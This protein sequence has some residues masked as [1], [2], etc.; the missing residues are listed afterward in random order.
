M[1]VLNN[2]SKQYKG[3]DVTKD[4][5]VSLWVKNLIRLTSNKATPLLAVD[6][7]SFSVDRGEV[8]GIYGSN[9]AGKT[10]LIK[11]LSGLLYPTSGTVIVDG[12]TDPQSIRNTVSYISTNGWMGLE[13]QLTA[14][15]NLLL[16]GNLFGLSGKVLR[17]ICDEALQSVGMS[18]AKDK[19]IS[20]LSAGMRQKITI[21]RGLILKRPVIFYDEPSISLDVQS[22]RNLRELILKDVA[23]T[24]HT[25][26]IA[27]HNQEDLEICGRIM[28]L[29]H[30]KIVAIGKLNE[31][32]APFADM[33]IIEIK[34]SRQERE[35]HLNSVRGI[36]SVTYS[37]VGGKQDY[38]SMKVRVRKEDFDM[39]ILID[40]L[41]ENNIA[42]LSIKPINV[43][44]HEVYEYQLAR[45]GG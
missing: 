32:I 27:S 18:E 19:H 36:E 28:M 34:I 44:L 13:W 41:I 39:N 15:E 42:V 8:F 31:L 11:L 29:S 20:E 7:V 22:A 24:N 12:K 35:L 16:Y 45:N 2:V 43:S 26:I 40:Y 10:T 23:E 4:T 1:I 6:D 38:Q 9:G 25:A 14:F 37:D 30:G 17:R 21:A 3:F 33:R 5:G